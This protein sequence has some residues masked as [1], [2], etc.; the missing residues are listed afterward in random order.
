MRS[1]V[2]LISLLMFVAGT[3]AQEGAALK[4]FTKVDLKSLGIEPCPVEKDDKTGFLVGGTNATSLIAKLPSLAGRTIKNLE[5]DMRPGAT[6]RLG[7]IG[8]EE[9][10]LDILADDNRFVVDTKKLTHQELARHLHL[11]GAVAVKNAQQEAFQFLYHGKRFKVTA[12]C[13]KN[14]VDSPFDD[15]TKTNCAANVWNVA[16][17]K[18]VSF[19]LLV[20]Y[21]VERYGFYEGKG[22]PYRVDPRAILEVFDFVAAK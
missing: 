18:T 2:S 4:D 22:T 6:S 10:L 9:D 7:F 1:I 13:F 19:S 21:M 5:K 11:V 3:F 16:T 12:Q 14:S 20:P 17:G 8:K 15:G